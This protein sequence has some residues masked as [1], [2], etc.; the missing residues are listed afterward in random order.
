MLQNWKFLPG[1]L[2][3]LFDLPACTLSAPK[4]LPPT[5]PIPTD[6][7]IQVPTPAPTATRLPEQITGLSG[8]VL[9]LSYDPHN[10]AG[11]YALLATNDLYYTEDRG[12]TWQRLPIPTSPLRYDQDV[13]ATCPPPMQFDIR[14]SVTTPGRLWV[15]A[16]QTLYLS[17]DGGMTWLRQLD[18]VN[19]WT[20]SLDGQRL[21]AL[22]SSFTTGIDGL[23]SSQDG[24]KNWELVFSGL[25]PEI[26]PSSLKPR[27]P[28]CISL[29]LGP[30]EQSL[31]L[32]GPG[33]IYRSFDQGETWEI[34]DTGLPVAPDEIN[35]V[36]LMVSDGR[37]TL[38]ILF[39]A[40]EDE[41]AAA[42]MIRLVLGENNPDQ[43]HWRAIGSDLLARITQPEAVSFFG[44]YA[45]VPE[46]SVNGQLYLGSEE[47]ALLS[48][49]YGETWVPIELPVA[50][51]I[52]RI[53][54]SS[55]MEPMLYL[56]TGDSLQIYR[57][58]GSS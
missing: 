48:Q 36:S 4:I 43:D 15:R 44:L 19:S 41:E 57:R 2:V 25:L 47:G 6:E 52:T 38:Y 50:G 1:F 24:G 26:A 17:N 58:P 30:D 7:S 34:F 56:W 54:P 32:G 13:Q 22:R 18:N 12:N 39:G 35:R 42:H 14:P 55:E 10:P 49:D 23:Y 53:A 40:G 45:L 16:S 9:S 51:R 11:L 37:Q 5:P 33:G 3:L 46:L 21:Y 27:R 28:G 20:A 31:Y 8:P 29:A